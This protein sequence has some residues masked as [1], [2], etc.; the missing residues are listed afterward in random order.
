M[1]KI[2]VL[3]IETAPMKAA[4][5]GMWQQNINV[6]MMEEAGYI[7]C[8]SAKWLG[9]P[10]IYYEDGRVRPANYEEDGRAGTDKGNEYTLLSKLIP[11]I[12]MIQPA[13]SAALLTLTIIRLSGH[14]PT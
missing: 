7:L 6:K 3:D 5:W 2:L 13:R 4:I 8:W 9:D 1:A 10:H 11:L 14:T 12:M